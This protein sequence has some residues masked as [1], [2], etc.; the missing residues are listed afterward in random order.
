MHLAGVTTNPGAGWVTQQA[1]NVGV[2]WAGRRPSVKFLIRD[3]DCKFTSSFD[4]VFGSEDIRVIK[5]PVR[6]P[7]ANAI[8]ERMIGTLRRE[9]LDRVLILGRSHLESVL[10]E[11]IDHYN[12]HRPH[13]SLT[14]RC[15][16]S[17]DSDPA[18]VANPELVHLRRADRLG[19]RIHEYRMVA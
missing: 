15:P 4:E 9:C 11:F 8:C 1:R 13:R 7:R 19:G 16:R 3:R 12:G 5:S 18:P 6:A 14:Q 2:A 17:Y 10:T